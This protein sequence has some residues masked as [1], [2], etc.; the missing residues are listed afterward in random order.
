METHSERK[1]VLPCPYPE[2]QNLPA[3]L[4]ST[5]AQLSC[6][7][8]L[9]WT[10]SS[11]VVFTLQ[12]WPVILHVFMY[13]YSKALNTAE[14]EHYVPFLRKAGSNLS[15]SGNLT[16]GK[17]CNTELCLSSTLQSIMVLKYFSSVIS[18]YFHV[19]LL[20][21]DRRMWLSLYED[22]SCV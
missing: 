21:P 5:D 16:A 4:G 8:G 9:G 2:E 13:L 6:S 17:Q 14:M 11:L 12:K 15:S 7:C 10:Q 19:F 1:M 18:V 22:K 3:C 20:L